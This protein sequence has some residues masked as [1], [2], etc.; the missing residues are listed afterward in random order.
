MR[1]IESHILY[2]REDGTEVVVDYK[3]TPGSPMYF[4]RSVG[5]WDPPEAPEI[6]FG[7]VKAISGG[8]PDLS[9]AEYD[10][11]QEIILMGDNDQ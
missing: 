7:K 4:N 1:R 5:N 6:E 3:L 10:E 8:V 9:D 11:I 2:E